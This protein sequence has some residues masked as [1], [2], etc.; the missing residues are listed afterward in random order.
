VRGVIRRALREELE[1]QRRRDEEEDPE[2]A[3]A[4]AAE[5]RAVGASGVPERVVRVGDSAP[6]FSLPNVRGET[7]RLG[8]LLGRRAVV[9]AFYR[10]AW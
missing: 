6:D 1:A 8:D 7:I 5:A 3:A 9:L 10:G 2:A 4:I